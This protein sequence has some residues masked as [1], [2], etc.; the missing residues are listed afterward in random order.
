MAIPVADIMRVLTLVGSQAP[1]FK[2]LWDL[3]VGGRSPAEQETLRAAYRD[4]AQ[5][6]DAGHQRLQDKLKQAEQEQ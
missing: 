1:A 5:A 6:N 3:V 2:A 4:V